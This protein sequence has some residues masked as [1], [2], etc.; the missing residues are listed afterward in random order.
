MNYFVCS[1]CHSL[2]RVPDDKL[3]S[4]QGKCG[5]CG[6]A[7]A[8]QNKPT[9]VNDTDLEKIV[10]L[11]P[12]PVLVDFYADWCGPC[13]S[14]SPILEQLASRKAGKLLV[15]KVDTDRDQRF[16]R[17][18]NVSG[19]PAVFLFKGGQVVNQATGT[20]P[21]SFWE[22]FVQPHLGG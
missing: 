1:S 14:L 18:L 16:A 10:R 3:G 13:R 8:E 7:L 6:S 15:V 2:N 9:H 5:R 19:I 22:G 21:M 12:V 11:S 4:G 20:R 17:D